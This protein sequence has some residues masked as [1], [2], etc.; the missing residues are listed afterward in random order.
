[1]KASRRISVAPNQSQNSNTF[2]IAIRV[3]KVSVI[4]SL[5]FLSASSTGLLAS[6]LFFLPISTSIEVALAMANCKCKRHPAVHSLTF[7][8]G[9]IL[10]YTEH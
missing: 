3:I 1:M 2:A 7:Q 4:V 9:P 6:L 10:L 8:P 5:Y